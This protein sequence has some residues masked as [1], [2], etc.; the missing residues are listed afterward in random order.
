[1]PAFRQ[2]HSRSDTLASVVHSRPLALPNGGPKKANRANMSKHDDLATAIETGDAENVQRILA[3][4]PELVNS[5]EWTPPPLHCA[6]LWNQPRIAE[7]LLDNGAEQGGGLYSMGSSSPVLV[8]LILSGNA[9]TNGGGMYI[10]AGSPVLTNTT[11]SQNSATLGG[12]V[13]NDGTA[14]LANCIVWDQDPAQSLLAG[15]GATT[16]AYSDVRG[17]AAGTGNIDSDPQFTNAVG[18]DGIAGTLDDDLRLHTTF[19]YPS[20]VIDQGLN[21]GQPGFHHLAHRNFPHCRQRLLELADHQPLQTLALAPVGFD[22]SGDQPQG[23]GLAGAIAPDKAH[24]LPRLDGEAGLGQDLSVTDVEGYRLEAD[25]GHG[26][27]ISPPRAS[28]SNAQK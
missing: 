9:A 19:S 8:N 1:M 18:A 3:E 2:E 22:L 15:G 11:F 17:G 10:A 23:G 12:A 28:V 13:Y 4:H 21:S 24:T 20:P 26:T 27:T 25:H 14:S 5:P 16:I 7:I 6:V